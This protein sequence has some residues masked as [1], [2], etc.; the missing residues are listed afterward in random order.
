MQG[1]IIFRDKFYLPNGFHPKD[2]LIIVLDGSFECTIDNKKHIA[3]KNDV[4]VFNKNAPFNRKVISPI[5]CVYLQF[6]SF[7]KALPNGVMN[8]YDSAR[9]Q[10]TIV[11]LKK[12]ILDGDIDKI[13]HFADDIF[14]MYKNNP[15]KQGDDDAVVKQCIEYFY[16]NYAEPIN[17]DILSKKFNMSKQW[18]ISKFKCTVNK[19]PIDY[20][21]YLRFQHAKELLINTK[22]SCN[23]IAIKCGYDN[24]YYFSNFFK[25]NAGMSPIKYRKNNIL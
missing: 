12:A 11:Y 7:P 18:L 6:D 17:L 13:N 19:T 2:S 24:A 1:E 22:L 20:L 23:E 3:T 15:A 21:N 16:S 5:T 4:F 9:I 8:I 25:K 10:G 14:I